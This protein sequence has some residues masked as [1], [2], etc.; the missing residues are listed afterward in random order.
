M[1]AREQCLR[2]RREAVWSGGYG[3]AIGCNCAEVAA[4]VRG[5]CAQGAVKVRPEA[6]KVRLEA[7]FA[8]TV[9]PRCARQVFLRRQGTR[10]SLLRQHL[11]AALVLLSYCIL[12]APP[13]PISPPTFSLH[14]YD[15]VT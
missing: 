12:S 14:F 15:I 5:W 10:S 2:C 3:G 9:R 11:V 4:K 6:V 13:H 7:G 1:W 8:A